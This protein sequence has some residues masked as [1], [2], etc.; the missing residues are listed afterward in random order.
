MQRDE[1]SRWDNCGSIHLKAFVYKIPLHLLTGKSLT[2]REKQKVL[3]CKLISLMP[4]FSPVVQSGVYHSRINLKHSSRLAT[5]ELIWLIILHACHRQFFG[6]SAREREIIWVLSVISGRMFAR[7][8]LLL[9]A[10]LNENDMTNVVWCSENVHYEV[11]RDSLRQQF[12]TSSNWISFFNTSSSYL[13]HQRWCLMRVKEILF[14]FS[15]HEKSFSFTLESRGFVM[16]EQEWLTKHKPIEIIIFCVDAWQSVKRS[17]FY[18]V[19]SDA[20]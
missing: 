12:W 7:H 13:R 5:A 3:S 14:R 18:A 2:F 1:V 11:D 17:Y 10:S 20:W 8:G 9:V 19:S 16:M 6:G 4:S 15:L